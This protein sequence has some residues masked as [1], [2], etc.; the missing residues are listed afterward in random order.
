M[1]KKGD[2]HA[3]REAESPAT[4][5]METV[6]ADE[7]DAAT[8]RRQIPVRKDEVSSDEADSWHAPPMPY[9]QGAAAFV[10][11]LNFYQHVRLADIVRADPIELTP[12]VEETTRMDTL[13]IGPMEST[14]DT[15]EEPSDVPP[16]DNTA[17][18]S[19]RTDLTD[20]TYHYDQLV[21][22]AD[23]EG[24]KQVT[25]GGGAATHALAD[26]LD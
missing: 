23:P 10:S 22:Q 16:R 26:G 17:G 9:Y 5:P 15:D 2:D 14:M 6:G 8:P 11:K 20:N 18:H 21:Q 4:P 1:V 13:T 12:L 3:S 25:T 19:W 7:S 24:D